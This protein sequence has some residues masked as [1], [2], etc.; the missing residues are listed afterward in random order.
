MV[1]FLYQYYLIMIWFYVQFI[2]LLQK[3]KLK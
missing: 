3:N 2:V 1:C